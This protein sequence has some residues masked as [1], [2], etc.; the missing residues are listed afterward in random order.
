MFRNQLPGSSF[1]VLP[2]TKAFHKTGV[3]NYSAWASVRCKNGDD[4]V[5]IGLEVNFSVSDLRIMISD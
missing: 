3:L 4:F 1:L 2:G 5:G